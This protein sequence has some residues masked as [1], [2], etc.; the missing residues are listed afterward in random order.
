MVGFSSNATTITVEV[1]G[2][3][4]GDRLRALVANFHEGNCP[5]DLDEALSHSLSSIGISRQK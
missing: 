3:V 4:P 5:V 1:N 2:K